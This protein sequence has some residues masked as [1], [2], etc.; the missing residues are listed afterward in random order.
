MHLKKKKWVLLY[1]YAVFIYATWYQCLYATFQDLASAGVSKRPTACVLIMTKP[2]KG[3][4]GQDEQKKLKSEYDE[5]VS[6]VKEATT[7]LFWGASASVLFSF[8]WLN[9]AN[10]VSCTISWCYQFFLTFWKFLYFV[11]RNVLTQSSEES[12]GEY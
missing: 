7:A 6:E 9:Y 10:S 11:S 4:L 12:P 2:V 1:Y 8:T 5:V 3:E